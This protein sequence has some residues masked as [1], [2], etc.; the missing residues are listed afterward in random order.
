MEAPAEWPTTPCLQRACSVCCR[1]TEMPLSITDVERIVEVSGMEVEEFSHI[2]D[3][4]RILRNDEKT[5]ACIF[6]ITDSAELTAPGTCSI[7]ADRPTGCRCYPLV[8]DET[9]EAYLDEVC[10]H[11]DEFPAIPNLLEEMLLK[12]DR[13]LSTK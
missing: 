1:E 2:V 5:R 11:R 6:L 7:H 12:L 9:D 10:P 4:L 3:G 8:L 13:E